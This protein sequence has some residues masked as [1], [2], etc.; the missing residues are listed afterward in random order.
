MRPI[1][2]VLILLAAFPLA[3]LLALYSYGRFVRQADEGRTFLCAARL[4]DLVRQQKSGQVVLSH[5]IL[6]IE[7][8][9]RVAARRRTRRDCSPTIAAHF[10][11]GAVS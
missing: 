2:V 8:A 11:V 1:F 10:G 9:S 5:V 6:E 7:A 4:E 3:S